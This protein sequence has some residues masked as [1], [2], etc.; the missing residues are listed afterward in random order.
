[1][2]WHI[3]HTAAHRDRSPVAWLPFHS[4]CLQPA[5]FTFY[6]SSFIDELIWGMPHSTSPS[7][8]FTL[9]IPS[10]AL[11]SPVV[12]TPICVWFSVSQSSN[13]M[14]IISHISMVCTWGNSTEHLHDQTILTFLETYVSGIQ[15]VIR[16][17][18]VR[19]QMSSFRAR[20]ESSK[21]L[22]EWPRVT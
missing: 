18:K 1:M 10:R 8:R 22:S 13:H 4:Y 12:K 21:W 14:A 5:A 19:S 2:T 9:Y 20:I 3:T 7:Y 16:I 15:A 17:F 6:N 11:G